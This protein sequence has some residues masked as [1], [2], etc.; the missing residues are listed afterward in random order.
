MR[1]EPYI[2]L[3]SSLPKPERLSQVKR[4][5]LSRLKLEQRLNLLSATDANSLR[6]VENA[7]DWGHMAATTKDSDVIARARKAIAGLH[8]TTLKTIVRDR[9][10]IRTCVAALRRRLRGEAAP[11][12]THW[13]FGRWVG[14]IQRNWSEADFRLGHIFHWLPEADLLLSKSDSNALEHLLLEQAYLR[15]QRVADNHEFDIEAVII[16]V[17]RWNIID[18]ITRYNAQAAEKRFADLTD[19][20][21]GEYANL[22]ND[23]KAV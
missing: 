17:L 7:L 4:P 15:L 9:L 23:T 14:H 3:M 22:F 5:P 21:L 12:N 10:E 6:L 18:R 8:N 2:M 19:A 13:G 16:Y 1:I 11:G 20:G